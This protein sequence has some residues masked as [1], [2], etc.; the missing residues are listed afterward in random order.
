MH[1]D[2]FFPRV[3]VNEVTREIVGAHKPAYAIFLGELVVTSLQLEDILW[4]F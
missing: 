3:W 2:G 1:G 4:K